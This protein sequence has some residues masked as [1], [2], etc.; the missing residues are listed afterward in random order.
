MKTVK[1]IPA[2][3]ISAIENAVKQ[4]KEAIESNDAGRIKAAI[5]D[6]TKASHKMAEAM[7]RQ[8]THEQAGGAQPGSDAG[9]QP[10]SEK[11]DDNVVDAEFEDVN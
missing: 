2:N 10:G 7:Y 5:D 9:P 1:K 8:Q 3:D 11:R 6:L 4:T